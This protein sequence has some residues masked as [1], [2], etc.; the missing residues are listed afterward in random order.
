[1]TFLVTFGDQNALHAESNVCLKRIPQ[2]RTEES[3]KLFTV[4]NAQKLSFSRFGVNS[5]LLMHE[6][7]FCV[8]ASSGFIKP[9]YKR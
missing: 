3:F 8:E 5:K 6:A 9:K 4:K 2:N 7:Q 1:M